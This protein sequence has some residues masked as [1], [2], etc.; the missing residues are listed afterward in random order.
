MKYY[1]TLS[2]WDTIIRL[3]SLVGTINTNG[4]QLFKMGHDSS[5]VY[6]Y[7]VIDT[8]DINGLLEFKWRWLQKKNYFYVYYF[9]FLMI[10]NFI[11]I[12]DSYYI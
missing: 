12:P 2:R 1:F 8:I 7:R 5:D 4:M 9:I 10:S 6:V 3:L 11:Y